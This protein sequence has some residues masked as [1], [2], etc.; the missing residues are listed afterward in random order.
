MNGCCLVCGKDVPELSLPEGDGWDMLSGHL[1]TKLHFCPEHKHSEMF[2]KLLVI[3]LKS[4]G[5]WT[6]DEDQFVTAARSENERLKL[7]ARMRK[8]KRRNKP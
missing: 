4:P 3:G 2:E 7:H 5:D 6:T 8:L 1:R